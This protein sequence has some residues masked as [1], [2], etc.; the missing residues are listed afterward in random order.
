M[1]NTHEIVIVE[2][3]QVLLDAIIEYLR[4][5][6]VSA[7]G[8]S[9]GDELDQHLAF[10]VP[11][12]LILDVNLPGENGFEIARRLR[13]SLPGLCIV[14]MTDLKAEFQKIHGYEVGADVYLAKPVS[15]AELL[16]VIKSACRRLGSQLPM[17]SRVRFDFK[18]S[19]LEFSGQSTT[20][21]SMEKHVLMAL[22]QAEEQILPT[23]RLLEVV[24]DAAGLANAEKAYLEMQI[25]RL[26]KKFQSIGAA[27]PSIKS[28]WKEG[29]KLLLNVDV[30]TG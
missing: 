14:M 19:T 18:Q 7:T 30:V 28:V 17:S 11:S 1:T 2:D 12:I 29:Y 16:A 23:W 27:N 21:N 9:C 13:S 25:F 20:L 4:G 24:T 15:P 5:E 6:G 26:R 22:I 8:F 3:N 10:N